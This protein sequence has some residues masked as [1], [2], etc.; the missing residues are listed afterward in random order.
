MTGAALRAAQIHG[1]R[2]VV[3][4]RA[5]NKLS[6]FCRPKGSEAKR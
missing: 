3:A 5:T 6:Q 2:K 1:Y 4:L